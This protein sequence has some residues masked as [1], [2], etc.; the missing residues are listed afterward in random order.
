MV[1]SRHHFAEIRD[2]KPVDASGCPTAKM[3]FLIL[4]WI[5]QIK[6]H[7]RVVCP[8]KSALVMR[9]PQ[10]R[11]V[12][13]ISWRLVPYGNSNHRTSKW[14]VISL[15]NKQCR[16]RVYGDTYASLHCH[17]ISVDKFSGFDV[18]EK[19]SASKFSLST[20]SVRISSCRSPFHL[21]LRKLFSHPTHTLGHV[22]RGSKNVWS[23]PLQLWTQTA[24]L[25]DL[26]FGRISQCS[27]VGD[28]NSGPLLSWRIVP[29]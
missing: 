19:D 5:L 25:F 15:K 13:N 4:F 29:E 8:L 9:T 27:Y 20:R 10:R 11:S 26:F 6:A 22:H 1:R 23:A 18:H 24:C 21:N 28:K 14:H 12:P 3:I 2:I 16:R 7:H 17:A